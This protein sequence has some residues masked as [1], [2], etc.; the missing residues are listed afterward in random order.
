MVHSK[1]Q[2]AIEYCWRFRDA[3][4]DFHVFWINAGS[5]ARF[6]TDYRRLAKRLALPCHAVGIDN[7]DMRDGVKDWLNVNEN[8]LMVID[9]ADRYADFFA[10]E[11][12]DVDVTIQAALPWSRSRTAMVIYTSR[13]D[14]VGTQLT[15]QNCL[16]L[17]VMSETEGVAMFRSTFANASDDQEIL[18]L[19]AA[20]DFLPLSIAH[21]VAYLRSTNV[22]IGVY[23]S[24]LEASDD[25]LLDMLGQDVDVRRRDSKAPRSVVKACQT[26]LELLS[27]K[28]PLAENLFY[29]M[30]CLERND[31]RQE[32]FSLACISQ[33]TKDESV[34]SALSTELPISQGD[35]WTAIGEISSLA[36]ITYGLGQ[37]KFSMH[38]HVQA[39]TVRRLS[40]EGRLLAFC[41]LSALTITSMLNELGLE[42][43]ELS[44]YYIEFSPTIMRVMTLLSELHKHTCDT[45][46]DTHC[47]VAVAF[48]LRI[49][50]AF[51]YT[52]NV[53]EKYHDREAGDIE[54]KKAELERTLAAIERS[55]AE[56][57]RLDA[58]LEQLEA[59]A[60]EAESVEAEQQ[61][62]LT[63]ETE[64]FE[65]EIE[66]L[67]AAQTFLTVET[68]RLEAA[69]EQ[70]EAEQT[71]LTAETERLEAELKQR[72]AESM[73]AE[74][75]LLTADN[76]RLEAE[77]R[78]ADMRIAEQTSLIADLERL[79]AAMNEAEPREAEPTLL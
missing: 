73:E 4:P 71:L 76:E 58:E 38:R 30:A 41:E 37:N 14:R 9:N 31:I 6:D 26:S 29:R 16:R 70:L 68:E 17:D 47:Y 48:L 28:N 45:N 79:K 54:R 24:R 49:A 1:T 23:L 11:E 35:I 72:E 33:L 27:K 66:Q 62:L 22:A 55:K 12:D 50:N 51:E 18:R 63:A 2:T 46:T 64:R 69:I 3:Y 19:L 32:I 25:G 8:W 10:T 7:D 59:E 67:E 44:S 15:D 52:K 61:T 74:Q 20:V 75:T 77:I 5:I 40:N 60:K 39:I 21:A 78:K 13:H 53:L 36:L 43:P 56:T 65:A 42:A 57:A 34:L